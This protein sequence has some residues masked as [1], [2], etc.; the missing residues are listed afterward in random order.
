MLRCIKASAKWINERG[1]SHCS[2]SVVLSENAPEIHCE[3]HY[4]L[5]TKQQTDTVS[6]QLVNIVEHLA[7][8]AGGDQK[9]SK[10]YS[11]NWTLSGCSINA[12]CK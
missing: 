2:Q 10:K 6:D 3:I 4:L 8:R 11:E 1:H 5:S 7:D 9:Q 12:V